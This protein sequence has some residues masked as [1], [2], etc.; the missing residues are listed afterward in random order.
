MKRIYL[1]D[2][3]M[4]ISLVDSTEVLLEAHNK[5]KKKEIR[6]LFNEKKLSILQYIQNGLESLNITENEYR[7]TLRENV[8]IDPTFKM[9]IDNGIEYKIVSAG[10]FLNVLEPLISNDI[11]IDKSF[12]ISN[13][14]TF[15]YNESQDEI[16]KIKI[17]H[18]YLDKEMYYGVDKSEIVKQY[19]DNGYHVTYIGDGPSDYEAARVSDYVFARE[20]SRLVKYC[21]DNKIKISKFNNFLEIN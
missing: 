17:S 13:D 4:T 10:T 20:N 7:K 18:P 14:I 9:F 8:I 2:F 1:I 19:K 5:D 15:E 11:N 16:N 6:K 3:D 21:E 12:I